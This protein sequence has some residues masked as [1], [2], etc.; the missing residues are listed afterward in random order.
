MDKYHVYGRN[1]NRNKGNSGRPK[2]AT[3][4]ENVEERRLLAENT[5][6][7]SARINGIGLSV[8][9]RLDLHFY[10]YRIKVRH[11]LRE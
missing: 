7:S 6:V 3:A 11:Q 2:S 9:S 10:P 4:V 5:H 8:A 1:L